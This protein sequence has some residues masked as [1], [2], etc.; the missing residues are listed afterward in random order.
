MRCGKQNSD[1]AIYC[2]SCG[3]KIDTQ[4]SNES[5]HDNGQ[6]ASI[7]TLNSMPPF[8]VYVASI[9]LFK[10]KNTEIVME[11]DG[12]WGAK[13]F[14][15]MNRQVML[16]DCNRLFVALQKLTQ[17]RIIQLK[18]EGSPVVPLYRIKSVNASDWW[19]PTRLELDIEGA[20][21]QWFPYM[22]K[23]IRNTD[24]TILLNMLR[25]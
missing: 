24:H 5:Q 14:M 3:A 20:G 13:S 11:M 10:V 19:G 22:D 7:I 25:N 9:A 12:A 16:D 18:S 15:Y 6:I 8:T 1:E 4:D 23:N 21:G 2:I 17:N